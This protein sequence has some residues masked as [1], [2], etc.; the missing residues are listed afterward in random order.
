MDPI[1]NAIMGFVSNQKKI[2]SRV[3]IELG[4]Q[5]TNLTHSMHLCKNSQH[6]SLQRTH[7]NIA[8]QLTGTSD[9]IIALN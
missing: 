5:C 6:V 2:M 1:V 7:A 9:H 8:N 3:M 4:C